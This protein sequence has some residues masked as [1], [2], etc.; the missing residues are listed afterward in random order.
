MPRTCTVCVHKELDAINQSL[1]HGEPFRIIAS[2]HGTSTATLQR[3]KSGHLPVLLGKAMEAAEV[4]KG[5]NLLASIRS[6]HVTTLEILKKAQVAG[7]LE[8]ALKAIQQARANVELLAK[9][10]GQ[11]K[12]REPGEVHNHITLTY[13]DRAIIAPNATQPRCIGNGLENAN[14]QIQQRQK[15]EAPPLD[16]FG[17]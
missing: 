6:L 1:I 9:L 5:E 13:V 3:H 10:D 12:D 14:S 7:R 11:L 16:G 17:K 2:R 4:V 8:T 15:G